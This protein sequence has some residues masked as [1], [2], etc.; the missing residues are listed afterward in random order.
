L[1]IALVDKIADDLIYRLLVCEAGSALETKRNVNSIA[2]SADIAQSSQPAATAE[3]EFGFFPVNGPAVRAK[4][5]IGWHFLLQIFSE[6]WL[7][8]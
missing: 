5:T 7:V 4:Q 3:T 1:P 6:G 2:V 8:V